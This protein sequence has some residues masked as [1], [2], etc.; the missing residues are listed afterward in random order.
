MSNPATDDPVIIVSGLP[1]SGTSMLMQMLAAAQVPILSDGLRTPDESN[2][3]G[4]YE[5]EPVKHLVKDNQWVQQARGQA[6]KVILQLL[7]FLPAGVPVRV[8]LLDRNIAEVVE[9]QKTMLER[10]GFN[11]L[12]P[13]AL[14]L[15]YAK[16]RDA[17]IRF[18]TQRPGT[19][20]LEV[21]HQKL[22]EKDALTIGKLLSFLQLPAIRG[23]EMLAAIDPTL[24]RI[25][26]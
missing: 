1:R 4:Y 24:N 11:S 23:P 26:H 18:L 22:I 25:K 7:P 12:D 19:E 14:A 3:K 20:F 9:S 6:V 8:L 16:Q 10:M 5:Y 2:P 13:S 17:A 21:P 15:T